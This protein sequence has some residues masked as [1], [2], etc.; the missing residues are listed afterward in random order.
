MDQRWFPK[1]LGHSMYIRPFAMSTT[2][3][4]GVQ[5][6][7]NYG[8]FVCLNPVASYF[9]A[10][11]KPINVV[12]LNHFE[13][14]TPKSAG[15]YKLGSNYAPSLQPMVEWQK[16]G[17]H[18]VLWT[19]GDTICEVGACNIFFVIRNAAGERELITPE[20][21]GSILPGITRKT[22]LE[23]FREDQKNMIPQIDR[24]VE[25]N[26]RI[27][28]VQIAFNEG[29]VEEC[30]GAGTAV[31]VVPVGKICKVPFWLISFRYPWD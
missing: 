12:I 27:S 5:P 19:Y 15:A 23:F 17:Y 25:K 21:D 30:F 10:T 2:K 20:L 26:L 6:P 9:G 16:K 18:Q 8:I 28:E 3:T 11:I 14:T 31:T 7:K 22:L 24:I 29:R 1:Q 13:R 4:L